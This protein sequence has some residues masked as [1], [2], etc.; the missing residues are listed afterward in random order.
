[1]NTLS[2]ILNGKQAYVKNTPQQS[3]R[4]RDSNST[5]RFV[6]RFR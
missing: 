6:S 1:M 5:F 4:A 2:Q 3:H